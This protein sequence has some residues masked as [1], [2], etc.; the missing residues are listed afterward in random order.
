M[1]LPLKISPLAFSLSLPIASLC[2]LAGSI[3]FLSFSP[4]FIRLSEL[5]LG[6]NATAFNRFGI[7]A[8]AFGTFE[9][10]L[11]YRDRKTQIEKIQ[12]PSIRHIFLLAADGFV[13]SM[14]L[15]F[16]AWS[17]TQ[18]NIATSSIMHNLTPLFTVLGGWLVFGQRFDRRFLLGMF[19]RD[20][21][22][23][24]TRVG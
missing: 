7:A 24:F 19:R 4:I 15:I 20:R 17:L 13:F 21:R 16:W 10:I 2:A 3:I 1:K 12:L 14:A 22:S 23:Y 5:D 18:T 9:Q 8:I 11:R 6:S